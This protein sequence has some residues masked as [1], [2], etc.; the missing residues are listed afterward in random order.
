LIGKA[1]T[2]PDGLALIKVVGPFTQQPIGPTYFRG[3]NPIDGIWAS[4]DISIANACIMPAGYRIGDHRLFVLDICASDVVSHTL[5]T[6]K[7]AESRRLNTRLPHVAQNYAQL[8]DQQVVRHNLIPWMEALAAS[9]LPRKKTTDAINKLDR[10]LGEYMR[11]A[12]K[13][14]RKI[15]SGL[16]PFS[17]ES[18]LWIRRLQ[19]YCSLL[20]YHAGQIKNTS[21]L[22]RAAQ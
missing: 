8:L 19:I 6:P 16:I 17:Q 1:L 7:R 20:K 14:C 13:K 21:N 3:S 18:A 22:R 12:E 15:K 10:E 2:D 11:W 9:N 5:P 4:S